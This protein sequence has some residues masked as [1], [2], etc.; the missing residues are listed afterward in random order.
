VWIHRADAAA[1]PCASDVVD[2]DDPVDVAPGVR[3]IPVPG[4]TR[5]SV[6]YHVDDDHLFTGDSLYLDERRGSLDVFGGA[7]WYSWDDLADSMA[8]LA[9]LARFTWVLP[10][11]G[12]WGTRPADEL[13]EQLRTLAAEMRRFTPRE[14]DRRPGG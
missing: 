10:G 12:K 1:A 4:H 7:T 5:G 14:W 13:H 3:L 11:H 2:G 8:R 9:D 6:V